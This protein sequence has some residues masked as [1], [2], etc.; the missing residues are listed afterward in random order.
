MWN[1]RG[2][3]ALT[4]VTTGSIL[5]V[6][7][8]VLLYHIVNGNKNQWLINVTIMVLISQ[9]GLIVMGYAFYELWQ[10]EHHTETMIILFGVGI[11]TYYML[12]NVAHFLL[13]EKY[14]MISKRIP[15]QLD[16]EP[17]PIVT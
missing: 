3:T 15:A 10:L 2:F 13:A 4:A 11:G 12:F 16:G 9:I 14:S 17:E 6:A 7:C 5:I 1:I 8:V